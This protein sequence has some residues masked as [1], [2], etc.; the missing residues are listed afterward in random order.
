[1]FGEKYMCC[2]VLEAGK[3]S[4]RVYL[5]K[6]PEPCSWQAFWCEDTWESGR[7]ITVD[8]PLERMPVFVRI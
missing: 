5:P 1:M 7:T 8:C 2:P 3:R 4:M 6:L